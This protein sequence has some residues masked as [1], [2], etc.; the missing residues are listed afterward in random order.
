MAP[1]S[2]GPDTADLYLLEALS[3]HA[4]V[5]VSEL[6]TRLGLSD[7]RIRMRISR[8]ER[9]GLIKGYHAVTAPAAP[10]SARVLAMLRFVTGPRPTADDLRDLG[11]VRRVYALCS[12]WDFMI[13]FTGAAQA[14]LGDVAAERGAVELLGQKAEFEVL[15]VRSEHLGTRPAHPERQTARPLA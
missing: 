13:E 11:G 4:R 12:A 6:T 5:E 1:T 3:A 9:S 10:L 15:A 14:V 8:L 2:T 7:R